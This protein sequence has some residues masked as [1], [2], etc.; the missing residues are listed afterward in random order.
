MIININLSRN[1]YPYQEI[2]EFEDYELTNC[3]AYEMAIRNNK[4]RDELINNVRNINNIFIDYQNDRYTDDIIEFAIKKIPDDKIKRDKII[5]NN[6]IRDL[7]ISL[8]ELGINEKSKYELLKI[9]EIKEFEIIEYI[10]KVYEK[11]KIDIL[12]DEVHVFSNDGYKITQSGVYEDDESFILKNEITADFKRPYLKYRDGKHSEL[13]INLLLPLPELVSYLKKIKN[14]FEDNTCIIKS[15][16]DLMGLDSLFIENK[17]KFKKS[18]IK[19]YADYFFCYD[20]YIA[21]KRNNPSLNY[22][23]IF[24]SID[25]ELKDYYNCD[26]DCYSYDTYRKTILPFMKL[27]IEES[28]YLRF[29]SGFK[30][31]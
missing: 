9:N 29:V 20:Y 30:K 4:Y 21:A 15:P 6:F 16:T 31:N 3:I 8:R 19:S 23:E 17:N 27:M 7:L 2:E 25:N 1:D 28:N 11:E 18:K 12:N 26:E 13:L 24:V 5:N 14:D 22:K 10:K